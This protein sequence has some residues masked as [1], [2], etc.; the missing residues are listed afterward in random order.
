MKKYR[1][2]YIYNVNNPVYSSE[3]VVTYNCMNL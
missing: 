2:K 1:Q 3:N